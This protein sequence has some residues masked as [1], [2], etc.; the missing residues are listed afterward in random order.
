MLTFL[1]FFIAGF[2]L[3]IFLEDVTA[4]FSYA[5]LIN[6]WLTGKSTQIDPH[7]PKQTLFA[8]ILNHTQEKRIPC[9]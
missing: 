6:P 1:V 4:A 8:V 3:V 5:I 2:R 7:R 9:F